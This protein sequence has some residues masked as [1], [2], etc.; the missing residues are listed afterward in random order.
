MGV[1]VVLLVEDR[2]GL[3]REFVFDSMLCVMT[4]CS[5]NIL[6]EW[7]VVMLCVEC[8]CYTVNMGFD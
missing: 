8:L 5:C 7:V 2:E 1:F 4:A 6:Y 3:I